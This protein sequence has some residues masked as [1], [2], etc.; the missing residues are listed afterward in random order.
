MEMSNID[1]WLI[2]KELNELK[3]SRLQKI[4]QIAPD[5]FKFDFYGSK[6]GSSTLLVELAKNLRL[7]LYKFQAPQ[8]PSQYCMYL[9]KRIKNSILVEIQQINFD[10][11]ITGKI[12]YV[13]YFTSEAVLTA[14]FDEIIKRET[15]IYSVLLCNKRSKQWILHTVFIDTS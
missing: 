5:L 13:K 7:S 6:S 9:R 1:V 10:R 11:I 2:L 12:A 14:K 3:N 15:R 8:N 4:Y